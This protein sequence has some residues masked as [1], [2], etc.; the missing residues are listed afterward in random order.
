MTMVY[1]C[2]AKV[3]Q[4]EELFAFAYTKVG[5][6]IQCILQ[7]S[8]EREQVKFDPKNAYRMLLIHPQD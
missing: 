6:S 5:D 2:V 4:S 7:L 3:V 1:C 8:V